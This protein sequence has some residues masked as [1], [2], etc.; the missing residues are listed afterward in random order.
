MK[1]LFLLSFISLYLF[2]NSESFDVKV[3]EVRSDEVK[4][5]G[6]EQSAEEA[7]VVLTGNLFDQSQDSS[8]PFFPKQPQQSSVD[9][10]IEQPKVEIE[11]ARHDLMVFGNLASVGVGLRSMYK[12]WNYEIDLNVPI[13]LLLVS[14][15]ANVV[16]YLT[17]HQWY[18]SL[19]IQMS[20]VREYTVMI[21][22]FPVKFGYWGNRFFG[23]V[24]LTGFFQTKQVLLAPNFRLGIHF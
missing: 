14:G 24:S 16:C 2:S 23:D 11:N 18:S 8:T 22:S 7:S 21:P 5:D 19:G 15:S 1:N 3:E 6:E 10:R 9:D 13:S 4:E 12:R 17:P 20:Y